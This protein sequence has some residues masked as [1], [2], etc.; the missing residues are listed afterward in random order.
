ME[1]LR[2]FQIFK[3]PLTLQEIHRFCNVN[4]DVKEIEGLLFD[5]VRRDI[6]WNIKDCYLL[7]SSPTLVEN[8]KEGA[9]IAKVKLKEAAQAARVINFFPFVR[10]VSLSGSLSKG[11][12]EEGSD[13]DFFIITSKNRMWICRSILHLFKKFTFLIGK[14][15]NYCMNYFIDET[16]LKIEEQ[17]QYTAIEIV[18]LIPQSNSL[19]FSKFI[20]A[21][22]WVESL[23]PNAKYYNNC[24]SI[25][26][27]TKGLKWV[28]E[29]LFDSDKLNS[30]LMEFT[31]KKWR[32]KWSKR[33][34][35]MSKYDR[36]FKTTLNVSKNHPNDYQAKVLHELVTD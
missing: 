6:L 19:L 31:D 15:H 28:F 20:N 35:D 18:T 33:G 10:M 27:R 23:T 30:F 32:A 11:Y 29:K 24:K 21:N 5:L 9:S 26:Y 1:I 2:Y 4:C 14:Q 3:F 12:F 7:E 25:N 13:I 17:N 34:F 8:K 16:S 22:K 36:A